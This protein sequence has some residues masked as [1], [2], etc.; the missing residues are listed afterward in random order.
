M[1]IML[2]EADYRFGIGPLRL[3]VSSIE[4]SNPMRYDGDDWYTVH[5]THVGH[6]GKD[7]GYRVVLVR[8]KRLPGAP[9]APGR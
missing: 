1:L 7:R 5:G 6:D 2:A 3:R 8:A 4:W 9:V